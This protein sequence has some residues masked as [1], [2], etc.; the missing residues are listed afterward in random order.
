MTFRNAILLLLLY[1]THLSGQ[2]L[3]SHN[4][5]KQKVPLHHAI[6]LGY[7]IIEADIFLRDDLLVVCHD[8]DEISNAPLLTELYILPLSQYDT[9]TL[10]KIT[11]MLDL[12]ENST[13]IIEVINRV[14]ASHPEIFNHVSLLLSGEFDRIKVS[15]S[16]E[17]L[18]LKIDGRIELI[19]SAI[20]SDQMPVVSVKITDICSWK[21][22]YKI[23]RNDAK[24]I[25]HLVDQIQMHGRKI[26]FWNVADRPLA[27]NILRALG[28]DII[29]VDDLEKYSQ[30]KSNQP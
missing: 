18:N 14:R 24:K 7:N 27:W 28:V 25:K 10:N 15:N 26:R 11:L 4:D 21:G 20:S 12:K 5:Y 3:L 17:Y 2:A 6:Q 1:A 8:E 13:K 9:V 30:Y 22:Y 19:N 16:K 29:G 23:T